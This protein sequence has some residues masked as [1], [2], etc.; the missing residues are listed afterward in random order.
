MLVIRLDC[1]LYN[2]GSFASEK[3]DD[4]KKNIEADLNWLLF[5]NSNETFCFSF[6]QVTH[7]LVKIF[8]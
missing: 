7:R 2:L 5:S 8:S 3:L 4:P 6:D 1:Q